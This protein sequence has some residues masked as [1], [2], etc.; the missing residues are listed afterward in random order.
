MVSLSLSLVTVSVTVT[1]SGTVSPLMLS[2]T[3][4]PKERAELEESVEPLEES[5]ARADCQAKN[6][7]VPGE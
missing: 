6:G 4:E 3:N 2:E 1:V 5:Q 7:A